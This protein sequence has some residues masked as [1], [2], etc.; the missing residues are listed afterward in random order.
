MK[1][2]AKK[3]LLSTLLIFAASLAACGGKGGNGGD[4]T[5]N[6][7][8]TQTT[9]SKNASGNLVVTFR[10]NIGSGDADIYQQKEVKKNAYVMA[11]ET[12]PT[13]E[14]YIFN[15]WYVDD[16]CRFPFEFE[17]EP[18]I[19]DTKIFAGWLAK[20]KC[21]FDLNYSG[22]PAA[23]EVEVIEGKAVNR[24][25]DPTRSGYQFVGW[26]VNKE[27]GANGYEEYYDFTRHL[28][29]NL[30]LYAKW[31]S[32]GSPKAYRFEAEYCDVITNANGGMGISG[33]T[34][35]GSTQGKGLVQQEYA[36]F[37]IES[38]N[39]FFVH[40]LY[41]RDNTLTFEI[42]ASEA[43]TARIV[44]RLS[45]EY[46][47]EGFSINSKGDNGASKYTIKVNNTAMDYG[48]ISFTNVPK[49][50]EGWK[51]FENYELAASVALVKG[52]N[53]VDMIT[54]N[55]DKLMGTAV[56]TAPMID[57]LTFETS[58]T[59]SWLNAKASQ[60]E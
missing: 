54:D 48:T 50:G 36:G 7:G 5:S 11:P 16:E 40:F 27:S 34:Y 15:G 2:I 44:M 17:E 51:K 32:V 46:K 45:A 20:L 4:S 23:E 18:I 41:A 12:D 49:Q 3:C 57:C 8:G 9:T 10:L 42:N 56:A 28:K 21:T 22:A 47:E 25:T 19:K 33:N 35:S 58:A 43:T 13:R 37:N 53:T 1:K 39:G 38:S 59:L 60:I 14:G 6:G 52:K 29:S 30:H 55:Q 26:A 31:G 24:P